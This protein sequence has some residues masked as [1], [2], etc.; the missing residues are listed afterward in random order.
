[1]SDKTEETKAP[2]RGLY[3]W[4]QALVCSVLAAVLLNRS[5]KTLP[6]CLRLADEA[7]RFQLPAGAIATGL[8][9]EETV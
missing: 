5:G 7:A 3:E 8:I 2:G 1:M 4:T 9:R 6:V